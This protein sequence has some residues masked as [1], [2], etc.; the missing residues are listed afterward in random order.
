MTDADLKDWFGVTVSA[1]DG[2]VTKLTLPDNQLAGNL[3]SEMQQLVALQ[4]PIDRTYAPGAGA[5]A[6]S[7]RPVFGVQPAVRGNPG[8]ARA[9]AIAD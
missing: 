8:S 1:V 3:P 9:A 7:A 6:G 5:A 4:Q 2:R